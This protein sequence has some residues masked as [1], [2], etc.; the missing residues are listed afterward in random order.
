MRQ[1]PRQP[2]HPDLVRAVRASGHS[3]VTLAALAGF[4]GYTNLVPFLNRHPVPVST[5]T[6]ERLRKL[7]SVCAYDGPIFQVQP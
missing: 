2:L 3:C 4:A 7:A 5:L 1:V 6:V